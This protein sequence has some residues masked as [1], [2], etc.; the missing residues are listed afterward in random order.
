MTMLAS[1][2]N[3]K[4]LL[5]ELIL[6]DCERSGILSLDTAINVILMWQMA[7]LSPGLSED[8]DVDD[9]SNAGFIAECFSVERDDGDESSMDYIELIAFV[10]EQILEASAISSIEDVLDTLST[11]E[12]GLDQK[13]YQHLNNYVNTVILDRR[14]WLGRNL[15]DRLKAAGAKASRVPKSYQKGSTGCRQTKTPIYLTEQ[16]LYTEEQMQTTAK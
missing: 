7:I 4:L 13:T 5:D 6:H 12:R 2:R 15:Q 8:K 16:L 3:L 9:T 11:Y 14:K 1:L 10:H